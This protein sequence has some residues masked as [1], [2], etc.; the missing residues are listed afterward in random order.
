MRT[1]TGAPYP[2]LCSAVRKASRIITRNYDECL[3]STGLRITQYTMLAK[4]ARNPHVAVSELASLLIMD[5]TTV[6]RNLGVLTKHGYVQL[7][8]DPSDGRLKRI[9]LTES[10]SAKVDQAQPLWARAQQQMDQVLGPRRIN[11]LL[12]SITVLIS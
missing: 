10:G 11:D 3:K 4:I 5:Q 9:S 6:T 1:D 12:D 7:T 8:P 2:C